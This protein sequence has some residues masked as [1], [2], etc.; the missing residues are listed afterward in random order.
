VCFSEIL[1]SRPV[2]L[3]ANEFRDPS[4]LNGNDSPLCELV[5]TL[6]EES[7]EAGLLAAPAPTFSGWEE[8]PV[9]VIPF[10]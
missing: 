7:A 1:A 8:P 5:V 6:P 3:V 9:H 10:K 4:K 2:S